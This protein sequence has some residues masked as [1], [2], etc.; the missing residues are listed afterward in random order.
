MGMNSDTSV[1]KSGG[2]WGTVKPYS[3]QKW[4]PGM[5]WATPGR[6]GAALSDAWDEWARCGIGSFPRRGSSVLGPLSQREIGA[7]GG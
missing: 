5:A 6:L 4:M 7:S 2:G 3:F 1:C